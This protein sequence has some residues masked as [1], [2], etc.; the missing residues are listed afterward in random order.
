MSEDV[1][2]LVGGNVRRIREA[3]GMTQAA[4]AG[5]LGVDRGYVSG[6]EQGA[7]N[8]TIL[9]LWHVAEALDVKVKELFED[10]PV[11]PRR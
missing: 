4:L 10:A 2:Q 11:R 5:K 7:R 1:R 9:T 8:A 6:L 3:S